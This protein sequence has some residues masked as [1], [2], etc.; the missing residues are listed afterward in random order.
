MGWAH[1]RLFLIGEQPRR[2]ETL[3]QCGLA[4]VL[5]AEPREALPH[6]TLPPALLHAGS[7]LPACR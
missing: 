6:L 7:F 4:G 2:L 5:L 1:V 3:K